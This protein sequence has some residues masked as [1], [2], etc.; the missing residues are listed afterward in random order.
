M[1]DKSTETYPYELRAALAKHNFTLAAK[2]LRKIQ[3]ELPEQ[4]DII[5]RL[6]GISTRK[7]YYLIAI[8]KKLAELGVSSARLEAIGWTK[9][10]MVAPYINKENCEDLLLLA[11]R[12]TGREL[13]LKLKNKKIVAGTKSVLLYFNPGDYQI[14]AA[15][16]LANGAKMRNGGLQ[17]KEK[18]LI[19]ALAA[20]KK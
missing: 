6:L 13:A 2:Y 8:D 3:E 4:F 12:Y 14:F 20:Y 7:A 17:G 9:L 19:R 5:I 10:Q 1:K 16:L 15:A 11:E 18:A